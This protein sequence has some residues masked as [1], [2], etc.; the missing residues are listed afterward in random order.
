MSILLR[1][2]SFT[3]LLVMCLGIAAC[4]V[5]LAKKGGNGG[6]GGGGGGGGED[7]PAV[8]LPPVRYQIQF[9]ES[10]Y[11]DA[12][13]NIRG[14]NNSGQVVGRIYHDVDGIATQSAFLYDSLINPTHA[15]DLNTIVAGI[16]EGW[17]LRNAVAINS[18]GDIATYLI[19]NNEA[20][21]ITQAAMIDMSATPPQLHLIPDSFI[22]NEGFSN[23][24]TH[25][26]DMNDFGDIVSRFKR[27]DG[28]FG[29]YVYNFGFYDPALK[30]EKP[31]G[32]GL[33]IT[34]TWL[35][36]N[37]PTIDRDFQIVGVQDG[38]LFRDTRGGALETFSPILDESTGD[39]VEL[40]SAY[41]INDAGEFCGTTR[42][43]YPKKI[44][45]RS[46]EFQM[47]V[48]GNSLETFQVEVAGN[49]KLNESSDFVSR[50]E[51]YHRSWG[52]W[53][54]AELLDATDPDAAIWAGAVAGY[55]F[56]QINDR[57]NVT[58]FPQLFGEAFFVDES[59]VGFVLS[60]VS[61]E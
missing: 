2:R 6:G 52:L 35:F 1:S 11:Q 17:K 61:F 18:V 58:D 12:S 47:Y 23:E 55:R 38:T 33:N 7:P 41:D 20:T 10:P 25:T 24:E 49:Q 43:N 4:G 22:L 8:E 51:F 50:G 29:A 3:Y 13:F 30:T 9:F 34:F 39:I 32:L 42:I 26:T 19:K 21:K 59:R 37:N 36:I 15:I 16:P 31:I 48:M 54:A 56:D 5:V 46:S 57:D 40:L 60:P 14:V 53:S 45:G 44:K 27:E 28:T